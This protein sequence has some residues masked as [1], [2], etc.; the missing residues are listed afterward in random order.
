MNHWG[1]RVAEKGREGEGGQELKR[2]ERRGGTGR[3]RR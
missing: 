3:E 1:G 2:K